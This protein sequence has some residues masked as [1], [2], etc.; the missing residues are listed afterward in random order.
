M[1]SSK[2]CNCS[3]S[4]AMQK[5]ND[6][7]AKSLL[8]IGQPAGM[9]AVVALAV[10]AADEVRH[11]FTVDAAL[12]SDSAGELVL[13]LQHWSDEFSGTEIRRLLESRPLARFVV[14]QGAWCASDGRT[15]QAWPAAICVSASEVSQRL[16]RERAV[17]SGRLAPLPW[18]AGLDEIFAFDNGMP[19]E[20][21]S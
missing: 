19:A 2:S 15:R 8:I 10:L 17:L 21:A 3:A 16:D 20:K 18:T 9:E 14:V 11:V 7:R 1:T 13:V 12:Q 4:G 5:M 6:R